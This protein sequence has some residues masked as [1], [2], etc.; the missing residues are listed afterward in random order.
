MKITC[1]ADDCSLNEKFNSEHGLSLNIKTDKNQILFDM[2][3]TALF[4]ENAEKLNVDL[5]KADVAVVSYGHYDHG[6]GLG[7]FLSIN[8]NAPVYIHKYAFGE[9][10]NGTEKYIGLD[11]EL[12]SNERLVFTEDVTVIDEGLTLLTLN[13]E[14]KTFE[15]YPQGLNKKADQKY[16]TDR[17]LHEQYLL[18]EERG[19]R[20][21]VSGCSHKG[22]ENIVAEINPDVVIGGFH[23]SKM[24]LDEELLS[25]AKRLADTKIRFYTCHCT[26]KEVFEF[27][28]PYLEK[29]EYLPCGKT[30]EI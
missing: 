26:G 15:I 20:I 12:A 8:E 23:F 2:G 19:K 9:Y 29:C 28:S 6:G 27:I 4:Y 1:L 30:V 21:L 7:K 11:K 25:K 24:P 17:F 18:I 10:Y 16:Q 3:Q 5:T 14:S 13:N 22:I